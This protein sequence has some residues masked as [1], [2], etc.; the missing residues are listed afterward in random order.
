MIEYLWQYIP[1][2]FAALIIV[3]LVET[4][5]SA[6]WSPGYFSR[7]IPIYHRTIMVPPGIGRT[8]TAEMIEAA[9]PDSGWSAPMMVRQIGENLFAFREKLFHFGMGYTP[10]MH[11]YIECNPYAGRIEVRG[12]ANWFTMIFSCYFLIFTLS[13]LFDF[14]DI[15]FPLFLLGLLLFIYSKQKKRFRQVEEAVLLLW[16]RQ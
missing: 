7:G 16:G 2:L 6:R 3:A 8:P 13:V 11:G 4:F 10:V 1:Y 15:I 9:L 5:L 12:Y 14:S